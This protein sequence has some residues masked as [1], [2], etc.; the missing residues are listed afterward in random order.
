MILFRFLYLP[1]ITTLSKHA[2]RSQNWQTHW[3]V[4]LLSKHLSYASRFW[5][6]LWCLLKYRLDCICHSTIR[7]ELKV[8]WYSFKGGNSIIFIIVYPLNS[9][10][11]GLHS[12]IPQ[13]IYILRWIGLVTGGSN[14]II[15]VVPALGMAWYRD[16]VFHLFVRP[17]VTIWNTTLART[18][19]FGSV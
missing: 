14:A 1:E 17:S 2:F 9:E 15:F 7:L 10:D 11:Q 3:N 4:S 12:I 19:L 13:A 5:L 8:N 6:S 16:L 18:L